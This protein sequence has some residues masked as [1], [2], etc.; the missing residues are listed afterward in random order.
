MGVGRR[1]GRGRALKSAAGA[2]AVLTRPRGSA[3]AHADSTHTYDIYSG[4][5][6][7]ADSPRIAGFA[8]SGDSD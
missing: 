4:Q 1:G 2:G 6:Q 7:R 5:R 3:F 8:L